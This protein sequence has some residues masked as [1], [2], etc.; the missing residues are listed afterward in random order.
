VELINP[1]N[2]NAAVSGAL[3]NFSK[4]L[5]A[6]L[7]FLQQPALS[8][9]QLL[10]KSTAQSN[11]VILYLADRAR[12]SSKKSGMSR[13]NLYRS[14]VMEESRV[15]TNGVSLKK[16]I[17]ACHVWLRLDS[18]EFG[19]INGEIPAGI[20]DLIVCTRLTATTSHF[21][22]KIAVRSSRTHARPRIVLPFNHLT[23]SLHTTTFT[24]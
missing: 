7:Y 17:T 18:Q 14:N 13:D 5:P 22:R 16:F 21:S 1:S 10:H 6:H 4:N 9:R 24:L 3:I 12:N 11:A 2:P 15:L 23:P 20:S 19:K 8:P